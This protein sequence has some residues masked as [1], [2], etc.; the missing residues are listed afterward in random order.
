MASARENR[1][2]FIARMT[3]EGVTLE[4][5]RKFLRYAATAQRLA[6]TA[7][8]RE[9][10]HTEER[11]DEANDSRIDALAGKYRFSVRHGDPRG[12]AISLI[13]PSGRFN[14]FGGAECGWGVPTL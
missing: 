13:L 7:C 4:D 14:S 2:E 6:V 3:E 12:Y 11:R 5:S 1:E 10:S 8:N 9:L